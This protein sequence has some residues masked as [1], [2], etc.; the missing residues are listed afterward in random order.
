MDTCQLLHRCVDIRMALVYA[1]LLSMLLPMLCFA[2]GVHAAVARK[3]KTSD[4]VVIS[5]AITQPA[6]R[7]STGLGVDVASHDDE[8]LDP[9]SAT[10]TTTSRMDYIVAT[11]ALHQQWS[12]NRVDNLAMEAGNP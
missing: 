3:A 11:S 8:S 7:A 9:L 10:T 4:L 6:N 12:G 5:H 2:N 1:S